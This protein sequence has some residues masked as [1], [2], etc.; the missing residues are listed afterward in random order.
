[1]RSRRWLFATVVAIALLLLAGREVAGWYVEYRWYAALGAVSVWRVK[2][3]NLFLLRGVTFLAATLFVF[4]NLYAVRSSIKK[5]VLPRRLAN[6]E[7]GEEVP[8]RYLLLAV[9]AMA[10]A[11]GALV[12]LP[13]N[14]WQSLELVRHGE[15]FRES[16]PYFQF[17]L[18]FWLYWLPLESLLHYWS[19]V[20]L[21]A[22]SVLVVALYALTAGLRWDSGRL[23]VAGY[24][25]RHLFVLAAIV[26]VLLGWSYRLDAYGLLNVGSG[27]EGA[28]TAIDHRI[29]IPV[30]L[31]LALVT[32]AAGML[33]AWSGFI[34]QVRVAFFTVTTIL[35][36]ALTLRQVVP[37]VAQRFVTP[38]DPDVRDR[39][40]L[41]TRNGYT[42]R[43]YDVD[44]LTREDSGG[45]AS[46]GP[47]LRGAPLW[48]A[49]A[50]ERATSRGGRGSRASGLGWEMS[51]GR[52]IALVL[53]Q[54]TGPDAADPLAPWGLARYSGDV[55][56][57]RG[58]PLERVE[59][60]GDEGNP[61]RG[62][63][64][65][66][67]VASYVVLADSAGRIAGAELNTLG[68]RI[69]HAWHLQNPRLLGN[70]VP[71]G[72]RIVLH[73]AVRE[74]VDAI[75]PFFEQ[76]ARI[77]PIVWRDSLVWAVHL[78]SVS[79]WHPL[80]APIQFP[81]RKERVRFL[82]HAAVALVNAQSGRLTAIADMQPDPMALTWIRRFPALFT[83]EASLD[84]ELTRRIPPA[85]DGMLVQA[86]AFARAGVRGEFL[87]PSHL[88]VRTGGDTLFTPD[89]LS[90]FVDATSGT[91]AVAVPILDATDRV[92]GVV[93]VT[94][95]ATYE[96]HWRPL[97]GDAGPRWTSVVDRLTRVPDS[98]ANAVPRDAR[99][100]RGAVRALP[101]DRGV[102]FAQTLY[103]ARPDG[104]LAVA[105]VAVL[106][107][108]SLGVGESIASAIGAPAPPVSSPP[109]TEEDFRRQVE[110]S[111]IEMRDALRR[112]DLRAFGAAYEALGRLLRAP[113]RQP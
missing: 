49:P 10:M 94:G 92:R 42:R 2:A 74:R 104:S 54:P 102:A 72:G 89:R 20:T 5:L 110:A 75:F 16:D 66:D 113:R 80:S 83:T 78:Y 103:A 12:A 96:P 62:I 99:A 38:G 105:Y 50:L 9:L 36:L 69:A 8:S 23:Y 106:S 111:Y 82:R 25:R 73:R 86:E 29:G 85:L 101:G 65:F 56:G 37:P 45:I 84:P 53:T 43:A 44:R 4:V 109:L 24:V 67:S 90:P 112:N 22:V 63:L 97:A 35:L 91:L 31:I 41:A 93:V 18:G 61:A 59:P 57:E 58:A 39:P 26:L 13:F 87:P 11:F 28:F 40:Y 100:I 68:G 27:Q 47:S 60:V 70:A 46:S 19:L 95:G 79:S 48:D 81:G 17:D 52:P 108:D 107:G 14:D 33:V 1:M 30:N 71:A 21:F 51:G 7:I 32:I 6:L 88:P 3:W 77:S 64:V 34:G 98:L 76:S 55:T 15:P